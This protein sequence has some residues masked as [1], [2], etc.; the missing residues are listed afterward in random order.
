MVKNENC[1]NYYRH[2]TKKLVFYIRYFE[3]FIEWHF[4]ISLK[5]HYLQI[6]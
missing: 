6:N 1:V 3:F 4:D 5:S 2:Y